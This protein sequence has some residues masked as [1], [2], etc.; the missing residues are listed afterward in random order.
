VF[1]V[2]PVAVK[3]AVKNIVL[4]HGLYADGSWWR[5]SSRCSG[6]GA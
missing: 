4:V 1:E 3:S 2:N 6:L 5:T